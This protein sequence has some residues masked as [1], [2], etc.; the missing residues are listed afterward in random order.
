MA[1]ARLHP[2]TIESVKE[3]VDIV[4]VVGEHVVLKKKGKE[5]V[6]ICPFHDDSKPS[7][8]VIPGKQFYYCFSC[9]AGGNAIKFLMEFQRQSFSDVV[10]ELA[11]KYQVPID[12]VEGPQQERLKQQISRR[13]KLY[14]VLKLATGWFRNQLNSQ[15]GE[16]ALNYLKNKR[17]L[18]DGTLINFELGFAPDNWDSL[19]QYFS[20][21]EKVS[22]EILESAGLIVPR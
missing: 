14:R 12:T 21:I 13:D 20:E 15:C 8:S 5:Y 7:M 6:G 19:L 4:D 11:K 1:S 10:L 9:G 3:R 18:S 17:H 16:K 22:V 2:R